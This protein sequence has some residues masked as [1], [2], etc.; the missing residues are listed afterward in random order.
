MGKI[1]NGKVV[2]NRG[3]MYTSGGVSNQVYYAAGGNMELAREAQR[4]A[5]VNSYSGTAPSWAG[6]YSTLNDTRKRAAMD[7]DYQISLIEDAKKSLVNSG[8]GYYQDGVYTSKTAA[9]KAHD[10]AA[11]NKAGKAFKDIAPSTGSLLAEYSG[12]TPSDAEQYRIAAKSGSG[13]ANAE[14][15][16]GRKK[17]TLLGEY[18][19]SSAVLG[20]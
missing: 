9:D 15:K 7:V 8:A 14:G 13:D 20:G 2:E 18:Y 16:A 11:A 4:L 10:Q 1:I 19:G 5:M 17:K 12:N 6:Q 3:P